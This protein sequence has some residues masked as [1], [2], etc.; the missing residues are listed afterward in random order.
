VAALPY[1]ITRVAWF[2]GLPLG[3]TRDFVA[4]MPAAPGM[5]EVGLGCA[6][7]SVLGGVLTHGAGRPLGH[8][9]STL[10]LPAM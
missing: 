6:V 9:K 2:S 8:G 10:D 4:M 5:P 7:A 3:M 1:E